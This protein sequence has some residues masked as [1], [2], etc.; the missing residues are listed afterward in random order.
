ME[1]AQRPKIL[2]A[3]DKEFIFICKLKI[4]SNFGCTIPIHLS[5][6]QKTVVFGSNIR[7]W[8]IRY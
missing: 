1:E 8:S 6:N 3:D 4:T 7:N 5:K 2:I